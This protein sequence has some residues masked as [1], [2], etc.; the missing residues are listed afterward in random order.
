[1][2]IALF[3]SV[4]R[5][6]IMPRIFIGGH[7]ITLY[8]QSMTKITLLKLGGSLITDKTLPYTPRLDVLARLSAE[9]ADARRADPELALV[10]GH[11][12]G[13]FGHTAAKK[14]GTREGLLPPPVLRTSPPISEGNGGGQGGGYWQGFAEVWWQAS[15]LNRY[16]MQSLTEA[17]I[18]SLA[19]APVS[20]VIA[21]D[22]RV[23]RWDLAPLKRAL[24]AGLI[25]VVYGDV[26]FDEVRGG[27]ILS[28]EDLFEHLA[29]ELQPGRILLAGL[30]E[31][32]WDDFPAKTRRIER[33]T[34][35]LFETLRAKLGGSHGAD[36]TGG[37][38]SKVRQML[39]LAQR[40]PGLQAHIFS[41]EIPGN[42]VRALG[43]ET[44]GTRILVD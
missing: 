7:S 15:M 12:S 29:V 26:I 22:G 31:A 38:E 16:V 24:A 1:V 20:A 18:L 25:P 21:S 2:K 36:V 28:T 10:L 30:E 40:V 34:P 5:R 23:A 14:H 32:V 43:G 33:I 11:G 6:K 42:L 17:G 9:I 35:A 37:M 44:L 39:E 8:N 19:L 13:S 41:G 27:T 4:S 3:S